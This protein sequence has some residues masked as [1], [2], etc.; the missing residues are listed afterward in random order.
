MV[1]VPAGEF[2]MGAI[3]N[4]GRL[5]ITI[6]GPM[7]KVRITQGFW[8][9][10]CE[11]T[12][13]QW[14]HYLQEAGVHAWPG[15]DPPTPGPNYPAWNITWD[16]ATA[17]CKH[18]GLSLPTEAQ[19]EYAAAGPEGLRFPW[20]N[21]WDLKKCGNKDNRGPTYFTWPV[22]SFP[23][24]TAWCGALDMAG[25]VGEW[26]QDWYGDDYYAHSPAGDPP[27]PDRR[28]MRVLRGGSWSP[29]PGYCHSAFRFPLVPTC[30]YT[31]LGFRCVRTP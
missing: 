3:E 16:D 28:T 8:L 2:I 15:S 24:G 5:L 11:V 21:D 19:W 22:G 29:S 31:D 6:T 9:G 20:G 26:C 18:Y 4:E 14:Q 1:W 30:R 23:Q 13:A 7:H 25:N 27:G 17:Y 12:T 10:K